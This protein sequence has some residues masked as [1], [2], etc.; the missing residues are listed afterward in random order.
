MFVRKLLVTSITAALLTACGSGGGG[1]SS[2]SGGTTAATASLTVPDQVDVVSAKSATTSARTRTLVSRAFKDS[3]TDYEKAIQHA[4][5]WHPALKPTE[6]INNILCFIG[7]IKGEHFAS[8]AGETYVALIDNNSC[9]KGNDSSSNDQSQSN[10][11]ANTVSYVNA[12]I[13]ATRAS[14]TSPLEV[15]GWVPGMDMNGGSAALLLHI[16]IYSGPTNAKPYGDFHLSIAFFESMEAAITNGT[17]NESAAMG[18]GELYTKTSGTDVGFDFIMQES[19]ADLMNG[20][21]GGGGGGITQEIPASA[22][23]Q[24]TAAVLTSTDGSTGTAITQKTVVGLSDAVK[25]TLKGMMSDLFKAYGIAYNASN[26]LVG[27]SDELSSVATTS[28]KACLSRDHFKEAVWHYGV[29]DFATGAEVSLNSGFPFRYSS[30]NDGQLDSFGQV[31]YWGL[32]T[33]NNN[34]NLDGKSVTKQS[35][36]GHGGADSHSYTLHIKPGR[37]VK[38]TVETLNVADLGDT[39]FD[40]NDNT[41]GNY[42]AKYNASGSNGAGFYKVSKVDYSSGNGPKDTSCGTTDGG[43]CGNLNVTP[44]MGQNDIFFYSQQLGG[45][46]RWKNGASQI[47]FYKEEYVS[48][49][50]S[51]QLQLLCYNQCPK[52]DVSSTVTN[53]NDAFNEGIIWGAGSPTV[54]PIYYTFSKAG[55]HPFVLTRDDQSGAPVTLVGNASDWS[56]SNSPFKYGYHSGMLIDT[57]TATAQGLP[58]SGT[59]SDPTVMSKLYDGTIGVFY[60]WQTGFD[61]YNKQVVVTDDINAGAVVTFDKPIVFNYTHSDANDRAVA[62]GTIA[63]SPY[64]GMPYLLQYQGKGQLFG[65]PSEM[66]EGS[67]EGEGGNKGRFY[68]QFGLKDGTELTDGSGHYVVKALDMEQ[69]MIEEKDACSALSLSGVPTAPSAISSKYDIQIGAEPSVPDTTPAS[70]VGGVLQ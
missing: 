37:L 11:A 34:V 29:Y 70:V 12:V 23:S 67:D 42:R 4:H 32:W 59:L 50:A 3:G 19:A 25:N 40:Y 35:F 51:S 21:G 69:S 54:T 46:V 60:E 28:Q 58:T 7:Q 44:M 8:A 31:G 39:L 45:G 63:T 20:G 30:N 15:K 47:T 61:S 5:V 36:D 22:K 55:A 26:V 17:V 68:P 41:S 53:Y 64:I 66:L 57:Q 9:D 56:S 43:V 16:T 18:K 65:I 27:K 13:T 62:N 6:T 49:L 33:Q 38:K 10:A 14:E 2:N 24:E 52:T 1:G 48:D